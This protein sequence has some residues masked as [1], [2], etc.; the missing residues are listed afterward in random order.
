MRENIANP[1][2]ALE[3]QAY[4]QPVTWKESEGQEYT[5]ALDSMIGLVLCIK[6][7]SLTDIIGEW[8][9]ES[10]DT[11]DDNNNTATHS[12]DDVTFFNG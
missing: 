2:I 9:N 7:S 3:C 1:K 5:C 11:A 6:E 4:V 8:I 12:S 10:N